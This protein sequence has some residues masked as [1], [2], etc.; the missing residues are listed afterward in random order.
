MARNAPLWQRDG[1]LV[2][3]G[4]TKVKTWD[5]RE[6]ATATI[7]IMTPPALFDLVSRYCRF[8]KLDKRSGKK[9]SDDGNPKRE[10]EYNSVEPPARHMEAMVKRPT[11]MLPIL[12]GV[13]NHP[14]FRADWSLVETPGYDP[15]SGVLYDPQGIEFPQVPSHPTRDDAKTALARVLHLL[16]TFDFVDE[17]SRATVVAMMLTG[18]FRHMLPT[19]PLVLVDAA[20]R[21]S[22]KGKICSIVS[23]IVIGAE[24]AVINQGPT[25]EETEKR[26][27][28]LLLPGH[29][30]IVF[31]NCTEE[32]TESLVNTLTTAAQTHIRILGKT[33]TYLV[34]VGS[35][36]VFNGNN[37]LVRGD[38]TR[39]TLKA[40][41]D[42]HCENPEERSFPYDPIGDVVDH[43]ARHVVDLLT[44]MRAYQLA[45][46]PDM[47]P[48]W[49]F[50][51]WDVLRGALIWAGMSDACETNKAVKR[52]DPERG[53]FQAV[54][55]TLWDYRGAFNDGEMT[56]AKIIAVATKRVQVKD[57]NGMPQNNPWGEPMT[58]FQNPEFHQTLLAVAGDGK[59]IDNPA[60]AHWLQSRADVVATV[61][62]GDGSAQVRLVRVRRADGTLKN[63]GGAAMWKLELIGERGKDDADPS[64]AAIIAEFVAA[65]NDTAHST[66]NNDAVEDDDVPF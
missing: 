28:S 44:V 4:L 15:I 46:F 35:V 23:L 11:L 24:P 19:A 65:G 39:R 12:K 51:Q 66:G 33:A 21:G 40:R 10:G 63:Y 36:I 52:D 62:H 27:G 16:R 48:P 55:Q 59:R 37:I 41:L 61:A 18:L 3:R 22:G 64:P 42:P 31:D 29:R 25:P 53:E 50:D 20:V 2:T 58:E 56:V 5:D 38:G 32:I 45:G 1:R 60:L 43:R 6:V 8:R 13:V 47:P 17:A 14:Y 26:L 54:C 57:E 34:T 49:G 7:V 30:V 9:K